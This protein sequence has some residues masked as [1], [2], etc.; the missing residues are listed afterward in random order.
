MSKQADTSHSFAL[1]T[2]AAPAERI[3]RIVPAF[4]LFHAVF[5]FGLQPQLVSASPPPRPLIRYLNPVTYKITQRITVTNHDVSE[6]GLL[7]LNLPIPSDSKEQTV[8][9][10]FAKGDDTFRLPDVDGLGLIVRS[11]YQG[12]S[13]PPGPGQSKQLSTIY[14]LTRQEVRTDAKVLSNMNYDPYD[15][16]SPERRVYTRSEKTIE[17]DAPDVV[18]LAKELAAR[19]DNPYRFARNAYDYVL[20]HMEYETPSPCHGTAECLQKGRGDCG[21]Y[22]LLFVGICRAGGVPA[23]PVAGCWA[24]GENPWHCW[25]EIQLPGVGW[26]PVDPSVGDRGP[27]DREFYFG[28]LDNNRVALAKTFNFTVDTPRGSKDVGFVQVG[29]WWWYPASGSK[30]DKMIVEHHVHGQNAGR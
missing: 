24:L 9:G 12:P 21:A 25:A 3:A 23:R 26:I 6:L 11:L 5:L 8:T 29:T 27:A 30:G 1:W 15:E 14:R 18:R 13:V 4:L 19:S 10:V 7:E 28:N 22:T 16:H 17:A 20:D 2:L